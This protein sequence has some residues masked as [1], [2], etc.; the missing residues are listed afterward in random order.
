MKDG[1]IIAKGRGNKDWNSSAPHGAGRL[2]SRGAAK[3]FLSL[4]EFK[5]EMKD[6][7]SSCVS[8][9][10]LD[11][12]PMAYK[13]ISSI[14]DNVSDTIDIIEIIKPIYNFKS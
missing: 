3:D 14:I 4:E 11:E 2:L 9:K 12:S 1:C 10:T 8:E 13:P 5:N 7:Y 6:V